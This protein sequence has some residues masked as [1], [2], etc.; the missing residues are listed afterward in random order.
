MIRSKVLVLSAVL[1]CCLGSANAAD[2]PN[3]KDLTVDECTSVALSR[4]PRIVTA[5][6]R[7]IE[8]RD[9]VAARRGVKLPQI[10][11]RSKRTTIHTTRQVGCTG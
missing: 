9:K 1:L 3:T 5:T 8:A 6:Q 4:N 7:A 11:F 2:Q 10:E